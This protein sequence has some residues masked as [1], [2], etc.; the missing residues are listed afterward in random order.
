MPTQ[1]TIAI[2]GASGF[3]GRAL[4]DRLTSDPELSALWRPVAITRGAPSGIYSRGGPVDWRRCDLFSLLQAEKALRGCDAAVYLV[5]SMLPSAH[6]TQGAFQ[7]MDLILADNFARAAAA[8]GVEHIVYVGGLTPEGAEL[9]A[10]LRSRR[11]VEETLG[12]RGVPVT[13]LRTGVVIGA[14]GTS[15]GMLSRL[16][17]R[18]PV[19]PC[20]PWARTKTQP[21]ALDDLLDAI[22]FCLRN[23]AEKNASFDLACPEALTYRQMLERTAAL[24]GLRRRFLD[25]PMKGTFFC[26]RWLSWVSG[27]PRELV[28]PLIESMRHPMVAR[29]LVLQ[30]AEGRP[31]TS[32]E[33]AVRRAAAAEAASRPRRRA[34][35]PPA[36]PDVRSVQR[37]PLPP[38]RS[39][40]WVAE[41]YGAMH[42]LLFHIPIRAEMDEKRDVRLYWFWPRALLLELTFA[43]DRSPDHDRQL[44]YITGGLLARKVHRAASRPRIEF[45]E[46]LGGRYVLAALH[47]FRPTL[48]WFLYN[49]TQAPLHLWTMKRF[50][51]RISSGGSFA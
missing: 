6:L 51:R 23:R 4:L 12:S 34:Y 35:L 20:P 27:S 45:R 18:L 50:A 1:K 47:D 48:P 13:T 9:S 14:N 31:P 19:I 25:L 49:L 32:F 24:L 3:I 38:G 5:H 16:L 42:P 33:E 17:R 11:E 37:I 39:A 30:Q 43:H 26:K 8:A 22:V 7:D 21:V 29:S 10:H 28:D 36:E 15:W 41:Q 46:V 40:H 2:A 44:F